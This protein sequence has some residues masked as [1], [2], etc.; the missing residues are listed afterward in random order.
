MPNSQL[1]DMTAVK[2]WVAAIG[3]TLTALTVAFA[4]VQAATADG[5]LDGGDIASIITAA[6]VCIGT[7]WGVWRAPNK[8]K[9]PSAGRDNLLH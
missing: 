9:T 1:P 6:V 7:V 3:T 5:S 4:A 8:V 2:A